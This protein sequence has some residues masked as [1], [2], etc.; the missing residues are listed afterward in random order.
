MLRNLYNSIPLGERTAIGYLLTLSDGWLLSD[1]YL[2]TLAPGA[3]PTRL[4]T[5]DSYKHATTPSLIP[6]DSP[7]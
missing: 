2:C 5:T 7:H 4:L 6:F 3:G 1:L